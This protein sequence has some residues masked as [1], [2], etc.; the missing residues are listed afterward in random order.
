VISL[1][2]PAAT[3]DGAIGRVFRFAAS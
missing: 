3:V 1:L 2:P